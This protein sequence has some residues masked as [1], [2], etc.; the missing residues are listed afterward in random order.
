MALTDTAIRNAKPKE[1]SYKLGDSGGLF[2]LVQPN[3]S[4]LWRLKYRFAGKEKKLSIG[5]Y[6]AISLSDARAVRD[7]ARRLLAKDIDPSLEKARKKAQVHSDAEITFDLIAREYIAKRTAEGWALPT[8]KKAKLMLGHLQPGIG[9]MP[10][11]QITAPDVLA[12]VRLHEK[13]GKLETARR[14]MQLAGTIFR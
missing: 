7:E 6:P 4:R 10:I 1:K 2:L 3:G 8:L 9:R 13:L 11:S 12:V 14:M 5:A